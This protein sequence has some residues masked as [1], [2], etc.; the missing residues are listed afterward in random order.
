MNCLVCGKTTFDRAVGQATFAQCTCGFARL[1]ASGKLDGY[2]EG[3]D[4]DAVNHVWAD[5][6]DALFNA[7]LKEIASRVPDGTTIY[8][9]GGGIGYF[10]ELAIRAGFDSHNVELSE[11]ACAKARDRIGA[12]RVH[13]SLAGMAP[14]DVV[15]MWCVIGH[16]PDPRAF[17]DE[18]RAALRPGGWLFLTT[19]N[20]R[21]QSMLA[22]TLSLRG[23][24]INFERQDHIS[25]FTRDS[26]TALLA[27]RGFR[28]PTFG[29][30]GVKERC[31]ALGDS[32]STAAVR[33]KAR[34]N[35]G[36]SRAGG[37]LPIDLTSEF[38]VL[39]QY[40]P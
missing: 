24:T 20:W 7:V 18:V 8:D 11:V 35:R 25:M 6:Q 14:A 29:A 39:V 16:T 17:L 23:R 30:W 3:R 19:P 2:W 5:T 10:S 4:D 26:L 33:A 13:T 40:Q 22:R 37:P 15:T 38:Q 32:R 31:V 21:F 34:W 28:S 9:V 27:S 36:W 1:R 12:D